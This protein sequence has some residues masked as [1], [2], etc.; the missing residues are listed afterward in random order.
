MLRALGCQVQVSA[1]A[2]EGLKALCER[3]FDLV[4]MDIQMPGMDGVEAL[5]WFR[6]SRSGRFNFLTPTETPVIAVTANALG[7]DEERFLELGFDDYL[8]KPFRQSQL[9]AMLSKRLRPAAPVDPDSSP[10]GGVAAPAPAVPAAATDGVLDAGALDRLRELDPSGEN[11]LLERVMK[12]FD[13]SLERLLP[14]LQDAQASHDLTG[15]RHVVHT[16]KSSSASIGALKMSQICAEIEAMVRREATQG[17]DDRIVALQAEVV[18]V[19]A[20]T[21]R[22]LGR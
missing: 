16:L 20:A 3:R 10:T 9:L 18:I 19:V 15:I 22:L 12:A 1:S 13:T 4:L 17:M 8:S 2:L 6:R 5:N 11:Q 21:R 14:Q 7:G